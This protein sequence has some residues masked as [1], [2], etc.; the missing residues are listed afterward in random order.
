MKR[1]LLL[2]VALVAFRAS[3]DF[4]GFPIADHYSDWGTARNDHYIQQLIGAVLERTQALTGRVSTLSVIETWEVQTGYS[5]EVVTPFGYPHPITNRLPFY[6]YYTT[7]NAFDSPVVQVVNPVGPW[8][9]PLDG[10]PGELILELPVTH[11]LIVALDTAIFE[12]TPMFADIAESNGDSFDN[13]FDVNYSATYYPMLTPAK[14]M[15][16]A[17]I[18]FTTNITYDEFGHVNG[19]DA[20]FTRQPSVDGKWNLWQAT[21]HKADLSVHFGNPDYDGDYYKV[22]KSDFGNQGWSYIVGGD[23][24][25][26]RLDGNAVMALFP[27][28]MINLQFEP[29]YPIPSYTYTDP[30]PYVDPPF[31]DYMWVLS[32][33]SSFF[34]S[35]SDDIQL[36]RYMSLQRV[37]TDVAYPFAQGDV[38]IPYFAS[39]P[40]ISS[41]TWID[42]WTGGGTPTWFFDALI[43]N[44]ISVPP[45]PDP[46]FTTT[47]STTN[48]WTT[49]VLADFDT[50][51]YDADPLPTYTLYNPSPSQ[52]ATA[53]FR[54]LG[55]AF[56]DFSKPDLFG[57]QVVER[58][59]E[60]V[61]ISGVGTNPITQ[62]SAHRW[63]HVDP[64]TWD[65][66]GPFFS[67]Y[68]LTGTVVSGSA[69][70][71]AAVVLAWDQSHSYGDLPYRLEALDIEERVM[72]L[73]QL[74]WAPY[75]DWHWGGGAYWNIWGAMPGSMLAPT[76]KEQEDQYPSD[77]DWYNRTFGTGIWEGWD[78]PAAEIAPWGPFSQL[79]GPDNTISNYQ[80]QVIGP[81]WCSF[82]YETHLSKKMDVLW[83]SGYVDILPDLPDGRC[84]ILTN[85]TYNGETF[86]DEFPY[87][88]LWDLHFNHQLTPKEILSGG[89]GT[90]SPA[91][92]YL[93]KYQTWEGWENAGDQILT[94]MFVGITNT[95]DFYNS[96]ITNTVSFPV[97][98]SNSVKDNTASVADSGII[99]PPTYAITTIVP[100]SIFTGGD[101]VYPNDLWLT[102][103]SLPQD[104]SDQ[105]TNRYS[106]VTVYLHATNQFWNDNQIRCDYFYDSGTPPGTWLSSSN[107]I[108]PYV[109]QQYF[110]NP[111]DHTSPLLELPYTHNSYSADYV[112]SYR[113]IEPYFINPDGSITIG[114]VYFEMYPEAESP[115]A[116]DVIAWQPPV[117]K[118]IETV[119]VSTNIWTFNYI[120]EWYGV[121]DNYE[122]IINDYR[123]MFY[124]YQGTELIDYDLTPYYNPPAQSNLVTV[125]TN[126][127][128]TNTWINIYLWHGDE[129]VTDFARES[130]EEVTSDQE[131]NGGGSFVGSTYCLDPLVKWNFFYK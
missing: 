20:Y 13:W 48:Y 83:G 17:G 36:G 47:T 97:K 60:D 64:A 24:V 50:R 31:P 98:R 61:S 120:D 46:A 115:P 116:V 4:T 71:G 29:W 3:A 59:I 18:G 88:N 112:Y 126:I 96:P 77:P 70:E 104:W 81:P 56:E 87:I 75:K 26:V 14:V 125:T 76:L 129:V 10:N 40:V 131:Q 102:W 39:T 119:E 123:N 90:S 78:D 89:L 42:G 79:D 69:P 21:S 101:T 35:R 12:M 103:W 5:N 54:A 23:F 6:S 37:G 2:T 22:A 107:W 8:F 113:T 67:H 68:T 106:D 95:I 41:G 62:V 51:Y 114:G 110:Q 84:P 130:G 45:L 11:D 108:W 15:L 86:H 121:G 80:G 99:R 1:L 93:F 32:S 33:A 7:T 27:S 117:V 100:E 92:E 9:E 109:P 105:T 66:T 111:Y 73:K 124:I 34:A 16:N 44:G 58:A 122:L 30:P 85:T 128:V 118:D 25:Y 19:G 28:Y 43:G 72:Y 57:S 63:Y 38:P 82:T 49:K 53:T 94:N 55:T 91:Y 52:N 65:Y 74:L 127:V